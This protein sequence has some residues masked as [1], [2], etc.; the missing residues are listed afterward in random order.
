MPIGLRNAPVIFERLVEHVLTG[1]K[2][3]EMLIYMDDVIVFA[4]DLSQH[5]RRVKH[6]CQ[7]LRDANL[8]FQPDKVHLLRK[9]VEFLG[10]LVN[11]KGVQPDP[12]KIQAITDFP[13]PTSVKNVRS[14]LG[15]FGYYRRFIRDYAVIA[16]PLTD[17]LKKD[18]KFEWGQKQQQ[19]FDTLKA[20]LTKS[21]ILEYPDFTKPFKV[22]TDASKYA[23]GA[24]LSQKKDGY[25]HPAAYLSRALSAQKINYPTSE[26]ECLAALIALKHW[27]HNLLGCK[28]VLKSDH[29]PLRQ[30]PLPVFYEV[31]V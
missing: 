27:R 25:D 23:V 18:K 11:S 20:H 24:V 17:L 10:H 1:L 9:E 8:K 4:K 12:K 30:R 13:T 5:L 7:R 2:S 6:L 26:K 14:A 19:I 22:T 29:E 21:P 3:L 16:K 28:F 15:L 31:D